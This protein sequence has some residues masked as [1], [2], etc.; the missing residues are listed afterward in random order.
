VLG[1]RVAV[2][3][4]SKNCALRIYSHLRALQSL[5]YGVSANSYNSV[6]PPVSTITDT[7][8]S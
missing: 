6:L 5:E 2:G 1:P 3:V 8:A 4:P 7:D